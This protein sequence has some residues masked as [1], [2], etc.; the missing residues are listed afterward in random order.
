LPYADGPG[1]LGRVSSAGGEG[2][3]PGPVQP[4]ALQELVGAR[5]PVISLKKVSERRKLPP[6]DLLGDL[7][8]VKRSRQ[9]GPAS[10]RRGWRSGRRHTRGRGQQAVAMVGP[11]AAGRRSRS[12]QRRE[13]RRSFSVPGA[14]RKRSKAP[15]TGGVEVRHERGAWDPP[16]G[17]RRR[18]H[19]RGC[20]RRMS[21]ATRTHHRRFDLQDQGVERGRPRWPRTM[22]A[23]SPTPGEHQEFIGRRARL[24]S[25]ICHALAP[26][27]SPRPATGDCTWSN[28]GYLRR[29]RKR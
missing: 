15:A 24:R 12:I 29:G 21:E 22:C 5:V 16:G 1:D 13:H 8:T 7:A 10:V 26:G 19:G 20:A 2:N 11:A 17:D 4:G 9:V 25:A 3:A 14:C 27:R 28:A 18:Q 23:V 6:V